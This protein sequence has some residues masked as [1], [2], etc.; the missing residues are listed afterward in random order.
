MLLAIYMPTILYPWLKRHKRNYWLWCAM[1]LCVMVITS[2]S[3]MADYSNYE[4]YF[5]QAGL[6]D[7]SLARIELPF[8]WIMLC[9]IFYILGFTYRGM[10]VVLIFVSFALLH[11][12]FKIISVREDY[13]WSLF[14]VFPAFTQCTQIRFFLS[15]AI[16]VWGFRYLVTSGRY[17]WIK[18]LVTVLIATLLHTGAL[19][20]AIYV[21]VF[22]FSHMKTW[23]AISISVFSAVV[24]YYGKNFII[25]FA[26]YFVTPMRHARYLG[27]AS[28]Q[29]SLDRIFAVT[30]IWLFSLIIS[31][32]IRKKVI[33]KNINS[34]KFFANNKLAFDRL[35]LMIEL[36]G[37][38]IPFLFFDT[39]FHRYMEISYLVFYLF[40]SLLF[41]YK[42]NR[43]LN[44]IGY[45][46]LL[47][48]VVFYITR[49]YIVLETMVIPLIQID[50]FYSLFRW[51]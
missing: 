10:M 15:T 24:I 51:Y 20:L 40:I 26:S 18:Y 11:N 46:V 27:V 30:I 28:E 13:V 3:T 50:N 17:N 47:A 21:C 25:N 29:S 31:D 12:F 16:S 33:N 41:T 37:I 1:L 5:V 9:K 23:K 39:S 48:L 35:F 4:K 19:I 14:L 36:T 43:I 8:A 49:I 22:L 2:S 6:N 34:K 45:F 7:A 32:I 38:T 44:R 42:K